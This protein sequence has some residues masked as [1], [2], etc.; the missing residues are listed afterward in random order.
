MSAAGR[1]LQPGDWALTDFNGNGMT[2]VRITDRIEGVGSQTGICFKVHP[3]L[4]GGTPD[5]LYDSAW[6]DPA[7]GVGEYV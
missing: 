5:S 1:N 2:L 4:K 6:F 3:R 7:V